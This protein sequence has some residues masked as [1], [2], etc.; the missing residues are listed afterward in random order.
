MINYERI[1]KDCFWDSNLNED[2]LKNIILENDDREMY[3]LFSKIIYNSKDKLQA[4]KIFTK[5]QLITYFTSFKVTYNEKYIT[6]HVL[7]LKS[8]LLEES[9]NIKG[10]EWKKR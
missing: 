9:H 6:K 7:I 2:S 3:K 4:L 8:L 5:E 1:L 10:L